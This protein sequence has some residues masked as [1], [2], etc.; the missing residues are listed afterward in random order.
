MNIWN[1]K[2]TLIIFKRVNLI[3]KLNGKKKQLIRL[4]M[5]LDQIMILRYFLNKEMKKDL[6]KWNIFISK[7]KEKKNK[8]WQK[9]LKSK[10]K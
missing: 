5:R 8:K 4:L 1:K 6:K 2:K 7:I 3:I 9:V 10:K